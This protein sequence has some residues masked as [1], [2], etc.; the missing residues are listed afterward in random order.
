MKLICL[1]SILSYMAIR[2]NAAAESE[3]PITQSFEEEMMSV[4]E[5]ALQDRYCIPDGGVRQCYQNDECCS[6]CCEMKSNIC[7][8]EEICKDSSSDTTVLVIGGLC[9]CCCVA[10]IIVGAI[11]VV[12]KKREAAAA[13]GGQQTA[14][15]QIPD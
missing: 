13:D 2:V 12:K 15:G 9:C 10:A 4:N 3:L 7:Y 5:Q 1:I 6:N 14:Y 11:I 8:Q